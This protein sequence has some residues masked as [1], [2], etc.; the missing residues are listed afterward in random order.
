MKST[1]YLLILVLILS[2]SCRKA[3]RKL[4]SGVFVGTMH[5]VGE[6]H[7]GN[8]EYYPVD[9][10]YLYTISMQRLPDKRIEFRLEGGGVRRFDYERD[11][12]YLYVGKYVWYDF[13]LKGSRTL[14]HTHNYGGGPSSVGAI[15]RTFEGVLEE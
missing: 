1:Y 2:S 15:R 13:N 9:T 5:D 10:T 12:S 3:A 7:N 11:G 8:G 4:D 14:T 6:L